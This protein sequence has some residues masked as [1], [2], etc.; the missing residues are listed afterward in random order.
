VFYL[1]ATGRSNISFSA[2]LRDLETSA[3]N[4]IQQ[5]ALQYR[6]NPTAD[7]QNVS[8]VADA[9]SGPSV[10]GSDTTLTG[11]LGADANGQSQVEVRVI[12]TN[13][14]GNDEWVGIDDISITST[15]AGAS[16]T[17]AVNDVSIVEGDAGTSLL[18]FTVTRSNDSTAFSV[19]SRHRRCHRLCRQRLFDSSLW[20]AHLRGGQRSAAAQQV[21]VTI[22]SDVDVE[23]SDTLQ[24]NLFRHH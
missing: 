17:L 22:N 13:A 24:L 20:H 9:T 15:P 2:R 19:N 5:V 14:A 1:D 12:T 3:D 16:A 21:S 4:A 8:Y 23:A 7:W 10:A 6:I 18:T 11:V